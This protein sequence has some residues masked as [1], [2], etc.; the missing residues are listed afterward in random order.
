M[1]PHAIGYG[2]GLLNHCFMACSDRN[3]S[4]S[5]DIAD[6]V[7]LDPCYTKLTKIVNGDSFHASTQRPIAMNA[8]INVGTIP[9]S[10][11]LQNQ[12]Q[13]VLTIVKY[14]AVRQITTKPII[15]SKVIVIYSPRLFLRCCEK[16]FFGLLVFFPRV[17]VSSYPASSKRFFLALLVWR[18]LCILF[19]G[20]VVNWRVLRG[21]TLSMIEL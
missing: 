9:S 16:S 1:H 12:I 4:V 11:K 17:G 7:I 3:L 15:D 2:A 5:S 21:K 19:L 13:N 10:F 18:E 8:V 14:K 6:C 20:C